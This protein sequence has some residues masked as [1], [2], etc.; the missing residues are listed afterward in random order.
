MFARLSV[1]PLAAVILLLVSSCL[2]AAAG[3]GNGPPYV[4]GRVLVKFRPGT[5]AAGMAR[6]HAA[7]ASAVI[8]E[9]PQIGVQVVGLR[10]GLS[11]GHAIGLYTRN[12][13]V[14][15]AEPDYLIEPTLVPNDP[16]FLYNGV[17]WQQPLRALGAERAWDISVGGPSVVVAVIDSGIDYNHP[18]HKGGRLLL[19]P[20][21]ANGDN[22]P[23]DD[24]GHGTITTGVLGATTNNGE[25]IAGT[26]WGNRLLIIKMYKSDG[27]GSYS[28]M[29]KG[30][31]YATD[32]PAKVALLEGAGPAYSSTLESAVKYA[33][34][35]GVVMV[36]PTGN[37]VD[38]PQYPAAYPEVIAVSGINGSNEWVYG[39]GPY[40]AVC[41]YASGVYT[42]QNPF[43]TT[44]YYGTWGGTSVAAPFVAGAA[45][46]VLSVNPALTPDQ[47]REIICQTVD[48]L[49]APGWDQYYGWGRVNLYRAAL[50]ALDTL[51][52]ADTTPPAAEI[53]APQEGNVVSGMI[54]VVASA[55]DDVGVSVVDFYV[56]DAFLGSD[57][58]APYSVPWD[59]TRTPS[60]PRS[61]QAA[62]YD[63]AGNG[64]VSRPVSVVVDNAAVVT[65]TF[66]GRAGGRWGS[67][68]FS[69]TVSNPGAAAATLSW[70]DRRVNLDLY[71][72]DAVGTLMGKSATAARPEVIEAALPSGTYSLRVVAASGKGSFSLSVTHP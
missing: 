16:Y 58:T 15:F 27:T 65:E 32:Y 35:K 68:S 29:A 10:P 63:R 50:A 5:P 56:D 25:G 41:A 71:L 8:D 62:A 45:A 72:Y 30:I 53:L 38:P 64:G 60:G 66:S 48:D 34:S 22:D 70:S 43:G 33:S 12:P 20:D 57:S 49:G 21:F 44:Y 24:Y 69:F 37:G 1:L 6:V 19:G 14:E 2:P 13:N 47:V 61:L 28:W 67:P 7:A 40:V 46:L 36:A 59:T 42:T 3:N 55:V 23:Y 31:T 51:G 9:V 54:D 18:D 39:Y 11:V 26:T 17:S 52:N 4:P